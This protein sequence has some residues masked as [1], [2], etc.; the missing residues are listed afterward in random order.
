MESC[1]NLGPKVVLNDHMSY[2][3]TTNEKNQ[4]MRKMHLATPF[5]T[6]GAVSQLFRVST[7]VGA[8]E[9]ESHQNLGIA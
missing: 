6:R 1:D 4:P 9:P 7:K 2:P 3:N 8:L 5:D